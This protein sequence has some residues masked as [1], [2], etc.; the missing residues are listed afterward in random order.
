MGN[1]GAIR[2]G[3]GTLPSS[4]TT[5]HEVNED[6]LAVF[7]SIVFCNTS[8]E[9]QKVSM[10]L[11]GV[12]VL[13]EKEL[14][15]REVYRASVY[16]QVLLA[17]EKV[18]AKASEAN[19]I[20]YYLSGK[21]IMADEITETQWME[22]EWEEWFE[23][24]QT[25]GYMLLGNEPGEEELNPDKLFNK[26]RRLNQRVDERGTEMEYDSDGNLEVVKEYADEELVKETVLEYD[27]DG[28]L[29][30]VTENVG[31]TTVEETLNYDEDGNLESVERSVTV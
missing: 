13:S 5:I 4:Y 23:A 30:K 26:H 3:K 28:N 6:M 9:S 27:E 14:K 22:Q 18:E 16:D 15:P 11:A 20:T 31:D 7:K 1:G 8:E 10:K 19:V 24:Q 29:V 21:R 2:L 17:T 25:E 12:E